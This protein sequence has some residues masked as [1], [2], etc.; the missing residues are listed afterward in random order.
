VTELNILVAL[1]VLL[2]VAVV[3]SLL[4]RLLGDLEHV[5]GVAAWGLLALMKAT[6]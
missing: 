6:K 4:F 1:C 5:A 2:F 3:A